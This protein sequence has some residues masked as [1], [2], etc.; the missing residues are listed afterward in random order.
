MFRK[1][2]VFA[3]LLMCVPTIAQAQAEAQDWELTLGANAANGPDFD[4]FT[5][6]GNG[7]IGYYLTDELELG[8]RQSVTYTDVGVDS[9]LNGSTRVFIDYHFGDAD[10]RPFV[11]GNIGYVYGDTAADTWAA[12]PEAGLKYYLDDN[13]FLFGLVEYQ[14]FFDEADEADDTFGDGQFIY[15]VGL[16]WNW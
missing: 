14:W 10:L 15:T 3:A 9:A 13:T 11:G 7:S 2:I 16:G 8:V 4:G 12:A 1:G 5:A 6:G